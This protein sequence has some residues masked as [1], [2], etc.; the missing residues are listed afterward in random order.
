METI[1]LFVRY[2]LPLGAIVLV[3]MAWPVL[4]SWKI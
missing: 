4:R 2:M 1:D 3:A